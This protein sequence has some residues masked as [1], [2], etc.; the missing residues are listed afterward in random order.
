VNKSIYHQLWSET[1]G[2]CGRK[3]NIS[4]STDAGINFKSIETTHV[5]FSD[6]VL[7]TKAICP[8]VAVYSVRSMTFSSNIQST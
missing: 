8:R 1:R 6:D 2:N 5:I 3:L 4:F 7:L